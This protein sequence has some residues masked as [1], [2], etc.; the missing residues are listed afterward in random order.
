MENLAFIL[1]VILFKGFL[2]PFVRLVIGIKFRY[3]EELNFET[4]KIIVANHNSHVDAIA[5]LCSLKMKDL[6]KVHPVVARDYFYKNKVMKTLA[7]TFLNSV[8]VS[9]SKEFQNPLE[10]CEM[11]LANGHS[12]IVFPE[13]TR[14]NA[15]EIQEFK[16]GVSVLISRNPE[17]EILP[18]YCDGFG[19]IMP[20]GEWL[21]LPF[22]SS[23]NFGRSISLKGHS[24]DIPKMTEKIRNSIL[25]LKPAETV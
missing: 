23:I 9:R 20:K 5:I 7:K 3:N 2:G 21:I 11:L 15:G 1:R 16:H 4:P 17:V 19:E 8:A 10:N 18:A 25:E 24:S 12:L 14:G 13:G 22:N 6:R